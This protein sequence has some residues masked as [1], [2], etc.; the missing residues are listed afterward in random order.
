MIRTAAAILMDP[1]G[2]SD[3]DAQKLLDNSKVHLK[4]SW[5]LHFL[6]VRLDFPG[7][8]KPDLRIL[9]FHPSLKPVSRKQKKN[10]PSEDKN[11]SRK[12]GIYDSIVKKLKAAYWLGFSESRGHRE[13]S[14]R[15]QPCC[16]ALRGCFF[17]AGGTWKE[18]RDL[19]ILLPEQSFSK[20]WG[21]CIPGQR[22][23]WIYSRSLC[24]I[25]LICIFTRRESC[26]C[27]WCWFFF[28]RH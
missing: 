11:S 7:S 22:D 5:L 25:S 12:R 19:E 13:R 27:L 1:D 28:W 26:I 18:R 9:W 2:S 24:C 23:I 8:G 21:C 16:G 3:F 6:G 15:P 10:A 20:C 4:V 14:G 17:H